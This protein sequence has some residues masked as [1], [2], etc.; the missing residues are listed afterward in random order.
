MHSVDS[1]SGKTSMCIIRTRDLSAKKGLLD[2][3][4][5]LCKRVPASVT[6]AIRNGTIIQFEWK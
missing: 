4:R 3:L 5:A 6:T 1:V 2:F